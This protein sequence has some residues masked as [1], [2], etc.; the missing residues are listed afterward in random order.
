MSF[1]FQPLTDAE[2]KRID[3]A[4]IWKDNLPAAITNAHWVVDPDEDCFLL[5]AGADREPPYL[6]GFLLGVKERLFNPLFQQ[7]AERLPDGSFVW[8]YELVQWRHC[9]QPVG[10]T[11]TELQAAR[12][13]LPDAIRAY[14]AGMMPKSSHTV[15]ILL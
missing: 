11:A 2:K 7:E 8:T 15:E 5:W 13:L 12:G 1:T 9:V 6:A 3:Y 14:V 4:Q 10:P